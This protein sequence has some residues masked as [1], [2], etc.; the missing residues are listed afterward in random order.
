MSDHF[1]N[2]SIL[3]FLLPLRGMVKQGVNQLILL[4]TTVSQRS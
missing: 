1:I 4:S 2:E 3:F